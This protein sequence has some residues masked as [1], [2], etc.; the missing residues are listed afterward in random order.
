MSSE[1]KCQAV[2]KTGAKKGTVCIF[3]AVYILEGQHLCGLHKGKAT[4]EHKIAPSPKGPASPK[5]ASASPSP[6]RITILTT[7]VLF[8]ST[9]P[10]EVFSILNQ[11]F[12]ANQGFPMNK[13]FPVTFMHRNHE[14]SSVEQAFQALKYYYHTND[15]ALNQRL[16]RKANAIMMAPTALQAR[17][18][19]NTLEQDTPIFNEWENPSFKERIL[20]GIL[21]DK[22][23]RN[24]EAKKALLETGNR[25][26]Q[27]TSDVRNYLGAL[28]KKVRYAVLN[29]HRLAPSAISSPSAAARSS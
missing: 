5:G 7:P 21:F 10:S 17:E 29:P 6:S 23:S 4:E 11:G 20:F 24:P 9:D 27:D 12:S 25:E 8:D 13:G 16:L 19:G 26:I 3:D 18:I 22:F 15:E 28:L 2:I 14:W 1:L